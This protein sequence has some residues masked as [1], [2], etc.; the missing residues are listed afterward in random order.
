[1]IQ[2]K[3]N[4]ILLT[5]TVHF[6][7]DLNEN[8]LMAWQCALS[9]EASQ[10]YRNKEPGKKLPCQVY[11]KVQS[12]DSWYCPICLEDTN[13]DIV[14]LRRCKC[15]FHKEC[16]KLAYQHSEHCPLCARRIRRRSKSP[17]QETW[18]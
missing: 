17:V 14:K 2:K 1:M 9:L 12:S 3:Y 6:P 10:N 18:V 13:T 15:M 5:K 11:V 7:I 8:Q 4:S 16:I